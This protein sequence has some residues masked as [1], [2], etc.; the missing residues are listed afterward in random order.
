MF[1]LRLRRSQVMARIRVI[2]GVGTFADGTHGW[3]IP[4]ALE[5]AVKGPEEGSADAPPV[6]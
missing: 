5:V 3:S 1:R 6:S 4:E 2:C